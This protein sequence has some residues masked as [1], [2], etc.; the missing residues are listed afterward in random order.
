MIQ[1]Q[2]KPFDKWFRD[3]ISEKSALSNENILR[4]PTQFRN[5]SRV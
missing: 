4:K 3:A 1:D 2:R 5:G